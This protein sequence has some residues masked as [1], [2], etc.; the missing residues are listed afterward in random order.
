MAEP[1][2]MPFGV[3][4]YDGPKE[5]CVRWKSTGAEG[6]CHSKQFSDAVCHNWLCGL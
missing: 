1:I 5:L 6:C 4:V 2:E 3:K